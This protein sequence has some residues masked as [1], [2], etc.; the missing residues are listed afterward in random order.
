MYPQTRTTGGLKP[1]HWALMTG[2]GVVG[3]LIAFALIVW[4]AGVIFH[5]IEIAV[6]VVIVAMVIRWIVGRAIH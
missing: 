4:V 5:V 2:V 1:T 3:A 6:I